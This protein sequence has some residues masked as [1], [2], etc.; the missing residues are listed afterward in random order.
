[1]P[2]SA[3]D[4]H[5]TTQQSCIGKT[6]SGG[7]WSGETVS[8]LQAM[9]PEVGAD[10]QQNALSTIDSLA[11]RTWVIGE[12]LG[13]DPGLC[14]AGDGCWGSRGAQTGCNPPP[15]LLSQP[16]RQTHSHA[17]AQTKVH[18][19]TCL[20][21]GG[22]KCLQPQPVA[23]GRHCH[24][25]NTSVPAGPLCTL[26]LQKTAKYEPQHAPINART[27]SMQHRGMQHP[28]KDQVGYLQ[29]LTGDQLPQMP[30]KT[31][32]ALQSSLPGAQ[33]R[34][35][36]PASFQ[37]SCVRP[38]AS[39][40][41]SCEPQP[42]PL[43]PRLSGSQY[44][45]TRDAQHALSMDYASGNPA[46]ACQLPEGS[47]VSR[48]GPA[49]QQSVPLGEPTQELT[50]EAAV[51][52]HPLPDL[53]N[54][55]ISSQ[56]PAAS[57]GLHQEAARHLVSPR[58]DAGDTMQGVHVAQSA[59]SSSHDPAGAGPVSWVMPEAA[60]AT[61]SRLR[62]QQGNLD[63]QQ[64]HVATS[65]QPMSRVSMLGSHEPS[66]PA[67]Q[68]SEIPPSKPPLH[69]DQLAIAHSHPNEQHDEASLQAGLACQRLPA[70]QAATANVSAPPLLMEAKDLHAADQQLP[71]R[72][73]NGTRQAIKVQRPTNAG[74]SDWH[75]CRLR[76]NS[77]TASQAGMPEDDR[78]LYVDGSEA[79]DLL[80]AP[81]QL[82][83]P[84]VS[85]P[86]QSRGP[87]SIPETAIAEMLHQDSRLADRHHATGFHQSPGEQLPGKSDCLAAEPEGTGTMA[88]PS[89]TAAPCRQGAIT[90]AAMTVASVHAMLSSIQLPSHQHQLPKAQQLSASGP[91]HSVPAASNGTAGRAPASADAKISQGSI[92]TLMSY[93]EAVRVLSDN[94]PIHEARTRDS[95]A[96]TRQQSERGTLQQTFSRGTAGQCKHDAPA[97]GHS[98]S[99]ALLPQ[100]N[101]YNQPVRQEVYRSLGEETAH[102][103]FDRSPSSP[104]YC[105]PADV[106]RYPPSERIGTAAE[107]ED[108]TSPVGESSNSQDPGSLAAGPGSIQHDG[109]KPA[110]MGL[111]WLRAA[112]EVTAQQRLAMQVIEAKS[113]VSMHQAGR[114]LAYQLVGGYLVGKL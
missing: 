98:H 103:S 57:T 73:H 92:P 16:Q 64:Q 84:A 88:L 5:S 111:Q 7:F 114:Q 87:G 33:D 74:S 75:A 101:L 49:C 21:A 18:S 6:F 30:Q 47:T 44:L 37:S 29:Q 96:D 19:A 34:L 23:A 69:M 102:A 105:V 95:L 63:L 108:Y 90:T 83:Q 26:L 80:L 59:A 1:M 8:N 70:S 100:G 22:D 51:R 14:I 94:W 58:S 12:S 72:Q 76:A 81:L 35:P 82:D 39:E 13:L 32:E 42:R 112:A 41:S 31:Q 55:A 43:P 106:S 56:H 48:H 97:K 109:C 4:F 53:E 17:T 25:A 62:P 40:A 10:H 28:A 68:I 89:H 45:Q 27:S 61:G 85:F 15:L 2:I 3:S 67:S 78:L 113:C 65:D 11:S 79:S 52:V 110:G 54:P 107:L 38:P 9:L 50:Q 46:I 99:P 91:L 20:K 86:A 71:R 36:N 60:Q 24:A 66:Y 104:S 77:L 93:A